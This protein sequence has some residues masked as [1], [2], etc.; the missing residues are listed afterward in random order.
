MHPVRE[1]KQAFVG[2][3]LA[4]L[5][6]CA[7]SHQA[8]G[9]GSCP[10]PTINGFGDCIHTSLTEADGYSGEFAGSA[11]VAPFIEPG[12]SSRNFLFIA[13]VYSGFTFRYDADALA[14]GPLGA[15]ISPF[16]SRPTTGIAYHPAQDV[17]FWMI[18]NSLVRTEVQRSGRPEV[19]T[20]DGLFEVASVDL[21]AYAT[22]LFGDGERPVELGGLTYHLGRDTLWTVDIVNDIYFELNLDGS[23]SLDDD[24]N[25]IHFVSPARDPQGAGAFGNTIAYATEGDGEFFDIPVGTIAEGRPTRVLRVDAPADPTAAG[26]P[27]GGDT[28]VGFPIIPDLLA[29]SR[30]ETAFPTGIAHYHDSCLANQSSEFVI[31]HDVTGGPPTI[32]EVSADTPTVSNIADFTC[33]YDGGAAASLSWRKTDYDSLQILRRSLSE[34][35]SNDQVV[36]ETTFAD[37]PGSLID[38]NFPVPPDGT[39]QYTA[40]SRRGGDQSTDV[41][42]VTVIGRGSLVDSI[43]FQGSGEDETRRS[44]RLAGVATTDD[45]LLVLDESTGVAQ[46][47]AFDTLENQGEIVGPIGVQGS[48][49]GLEIDPTTGRI[50]WLARFGPHNVLQT[51]GLDGTNAGEIVSV[52]APLNVLRTPVYGD[53]SY[54]AGA[55]QLWLVDTENHLIH[56][57]TLDGR[58]VEGSRINEPVADSV[59]GGGIDI[60]AADESSVTMDITVGP[61][62]EGIADSIVRLTFQRDSLADREQA[63]NVHL[64]R[65]I[66][67]NRPVGIAR[68]DNATGSTEYV[69][70]SDT[71]RIY[72]LSMNTA[73]IDSLPLRRGDANNDGDINISDPSYLLAA[74]FLGQ[75]VRPFACQDAADSNDSGTIE[76]TD[77]IVIFNYLF[78]ADAAPAA[79]SPGC[80]FD[81]TSS[82][83]ECD[84]SFCVGG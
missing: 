18:D 51:T 62:N 65:V 76:I 70:A 22:A 80:G 11:V 34:R 27:I 36:F 82:E 61:A 23:L 31:V 60:V 45:N 2:C 6:V 30:R 79:P 43:E 52:Q 78:R 54:D 12:P 13:D 8:L 71:N 77:A 48:T 47:Y 42:C 67:A 46:R 15:L 29:A 73:R 57:C 69:S 81:A 40:R 66:N 10:C 55:E 14:N 32:L 37:D 75:T 28:G 59:L 25:P 72:R 26:F 38:V 83:L 21:A 84:A 39:Y 49:T 56:A 9:Q 5:A 44:V 68:H 1:M 20:F 4:V 41:H 7:L 19:H 50:V 16:G 17:L 35:D 74:L 33:V 64:R 24:G 63:W 3:G 53:L 58:F